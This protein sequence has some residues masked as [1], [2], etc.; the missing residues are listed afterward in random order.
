[1]SEWIKIKCRECNDGTIIY[2]SEWQIVPH[3]CDLC[4]ARR[5]DRKEMALRIYF[6]DKR[7]IQGKKALTEDHKNEL[8]AI[9]DIERKL[10]D[11]KNIYKDNERGIFEELIKIKKVRDILFK[12]EKDIRKSNS[13]N[14][15]N[16]INL[17]I[18]TT[19]TFV[20]GGLPGNK[21]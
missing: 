21:R 3:F 10:D 1:M 19:A 8:K 11:L 6:K 12:W 18:G 7:S 13:G 14:K 20:Q 9:D 17:G 16:K 2:N 4:R 5:V 15:R